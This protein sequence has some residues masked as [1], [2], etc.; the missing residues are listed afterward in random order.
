MED[1]NTTEP[2]ANPLACPECNVEAGHLAGCSRLLPQSDNILNP[3]DIPATIESDGNP[4]ASTE[5]EEVQEP[6]QV[7]STGESVTGSEGVLPQAKQEAHPNLNAGNPAPEGNNYN[8]KWKTAEERIVACEQYC[9]YL[10]Q[11]RSKKFYP[12]ADENT[13]KRYIETYPKE[14]RPEKIADAERKGLSAL[15]L[16]LMNASL[17]KIPNANATLLI[18]LSKNKLNW[19]D[20]V[21]HTSD[22]KALPTPIANGLATQD[23]STDNSNTQTS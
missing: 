20:K 14:F 15:E 18:W 5:T 19:R 16:S 10:R 3:Q 21:D 4:K 8:E 22:G 2:Q 9:S 7:G 1:P 17:G 23:V 13:I 12:D 6:G 11:G